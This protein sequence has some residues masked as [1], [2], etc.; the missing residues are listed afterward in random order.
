MSVT[1]GRVSGILAAVVLASAVMPSPAGAKPRRTL[2]SSPPWKYR[3]E[4][5]EVLL[6]PAAALYG[7]NSANGVLHVITKSPFTSRGGVLTVDAGERGVVRGS[8][9]WAQ[10][11]GDKLGVQ[12]SGEYMRG[13]D[14]H[15][16]DPAEP[17]SISRPT[18]AVSAGAEWI[19]TSRSAWLPSRACGRVRR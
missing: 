2:A 17:D 4:R 3:S 19:N 5:I 8:G 14:W 1:I 12:V 7:P 18:G 10:V 15:Y 9:R 6:G 16:D 11:F 13:E